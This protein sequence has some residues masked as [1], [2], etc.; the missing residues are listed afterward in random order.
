MVYAGTGD[1]E[2]KNKQDTQPHRQPE[3]MG[4]L[5]VLQLH[6]IAERNAMT[7]DSLEE[8]RISLTCILRL[9]SITKECQD[10]NS[11]QEPRRYAAF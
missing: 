6:S 10:R 8:G 5:Y 7:K 9:Q 3:G 11:R 2:M 1:R 4:I